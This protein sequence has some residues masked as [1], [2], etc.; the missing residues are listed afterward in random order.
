MGALLYA[1]GHAGFKGMLF[2]I[3]GVLLDEYGTVDEGQLHGRAGS[4]HVRAAVE[5]PFPG[6]FFS[7][8][9]GPR[10]RGRFGHFQKCFFLTPRIS[11]DFG[12]FFP[13][14]DTVS[15]FRARAREGN[16]H[17]SHHRIKFSTR[18]F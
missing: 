7:S 5:R 10:K 15:H 17:I 18:M 11:W 2:L 4:R 13:K 14:C 9:S 6:A 16:A 12:V 8:F 1:V 3:V